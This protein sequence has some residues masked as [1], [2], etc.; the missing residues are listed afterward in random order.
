MRTRIRNYLIAS[1]IAGAAALWLASGAITRGGDPGE[2]APEQQGQPF[3]VAVKEQTAEEIQRF[4][5]LQGETI[6]DRAA[7]IRAQTSGTVETMAVD[8]GDRVESGEL[9]AQLAMDD[10]QARLR[11]VQATLRQRREAFE[12][13]Q[14]LQERGHQASLEL[15]SARAALEA[16]RAAV[17]RVETDIAHTRIGAPFAGAIGR[18]HVTE[19]DFVAAGTQVVTLVDNDPM[20]VR[21]H[22]SERDIDQLDR[23]QPVEVLLPGRETPLQGRISSVAP[24]ADSSTRTYPLEVTVSEAPSSLS[25]GSATVRIPAGRVMAHRV[26]P[27]VLALDA[28]GELGLKTVDASEHVRFQPVTIERSGPDGVWVSGLPHQARIITRG[29]GFVSAGEPVQAEKQTPQAQTDE[30]EVTP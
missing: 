26:S 6:P 13:A 19:G 24:Q 17:E 29:A 1:A 12:A 30:A 22:V 16:A 23:A 11:E 9:L 7:Q 2:S 25:G 5:S 20:K 21:V 27:A 28:D 4:V 14:E 3:R 8:V 15:E 10:R 18:R